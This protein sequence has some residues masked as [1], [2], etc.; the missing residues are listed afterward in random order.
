MDVD[1]D[2]SRPRKVKGTVPASLAS[3]VMRRVHKGMSALASKAWPGVRG[4][5][6]Y[7]RAPA[8]AGHNPYV[9]GETRG[10]RNKFG[11][12]LDLDPSK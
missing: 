12:F 6:W 2:P 4:P 5:W 7:L 9:T 3:R 11:A 8:T 1:P 10:N